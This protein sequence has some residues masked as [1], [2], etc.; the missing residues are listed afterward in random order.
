MHRN[1]RIA[2][3]SLALAALAA[4][5]PPKPPE[6]ERRP[7]PQV[8]AQPRS[9]IVQTAESYKGAARDAVSTA[10]Q[11]AQSERAQIDATTH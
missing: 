6:E 7:D 4:C 9:A 3:A 11:A 5:A 1:A 10:Q 8:A 2:A